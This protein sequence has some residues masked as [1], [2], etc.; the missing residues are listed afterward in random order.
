MRQGKLTILA[1]LALLAVAAATL[2]TACGYS[3]K[4]TSSSANA[5]VKKETCQ[6][7][8]AVLS[9]G[10]DPEAD[11]VG[12]AQAQV[13]PLRQIHTSDEKLHEAI[14]RL[15]S[16]YETFSDRNGVSHSAKSAVTA[17]ADRVNAICPGAAS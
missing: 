9:D 5:N 8:E 17:A 13:L 16:V 1:L 10:P 7:V 6:Q 12:Y 15:A 4:T 14:D 3:S 2:L 11:P